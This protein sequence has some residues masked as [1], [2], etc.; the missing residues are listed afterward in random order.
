MGFVGG[1]ERAGGG[2]QSDFENVAKHGRH[3]VQELGVVVRSE[4]AL[5][6][7]PIQTGPAVVTQKYVISVSCFTAI[8]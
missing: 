6:T 1:V 3:L 2:D 7:P 4:I 8:T 5:V